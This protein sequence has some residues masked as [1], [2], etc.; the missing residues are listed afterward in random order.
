[1]TEDN[2]KTAIEIAAQIWCDPRCADSILDPNLVRVFA[3]RL[4]PYLDLAEAAKEKDALQRHIDRMPWRY[5]RLQYSLD[6]EH[7]WGDV[8]ECS[9]FKSPEA[10]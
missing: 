2:L 10:K 3:E 4:K 1:M 9:N 8:V 7:W 5:V 6:G